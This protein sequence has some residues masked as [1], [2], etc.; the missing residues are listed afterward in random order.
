MKLTLKE[1]ENVVSIFDLD[2]EIMKLVLRDMLIS[3]MNNDNSSIFEIL[4]KLG[5]VPSGIA[6]YHISTL[7][8]HEQFCI[9]EAYHNV[10]NNL[11]VGSNV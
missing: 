5:N 4:W 7:T 10:I 8:E 1:I 3:R 9:L 2:R 11:G 6:E